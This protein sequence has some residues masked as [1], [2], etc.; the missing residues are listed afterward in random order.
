M[1]KDTLLYSAEELKFWEVRLFAES[2]ANTEKS[3]SLHISL[4]AYQAMK[5]RE[6]VVRVIEDLEIII[7]KDE[8][9]VKDMD[10]YEWALKGAE[11][12]SR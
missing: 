6:N 11:I 10:R 1:R 9:W 8:A 2:A 12:A 4:K 7:A 3:D 5:D